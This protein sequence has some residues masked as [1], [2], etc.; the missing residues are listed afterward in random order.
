MAEQRRSLSFS[1]WW[2]IAGGALAM[3]M[4]GTFQ[5]VWSSI[6]GPL[7]TQIGTTEATLGTLFT[8]VI[9]VQTVVQFPA[10]WVRDRYGPR[11]PTLAG[12]LLMTGGYVGLSIASSPV[13]AGLAVVAG[14]GGAGAIYTVAV[15]TPV[16][17][18]DEYRGLATGIITMSYAVLSFGLIPLTRGSILG[19]FQRTLL[20]FAVLAALTCLLAAIILRDPQI[21]TTPGGT[22]EKTDPV[23]ETKE[24]AWTDVIQTW[25]FWILYGAFVIVNGVGLMLIGKLIAFSD[26]MELSAGVAT[27]AASIIAIADGSGVLIVGGLSDR[28][29]SI[30]TVGSS[31]LLSAIGIAGAVVSGSSGIAPV[32]IICVAVAG[33]FRSPVFAI[34]PTL[35]GEYYGRKYSSE[36]YATLY[37]AKLWG[38]LFAGSVASILITRVG[39]S[40]SFLI[41]AI[42]M[43]LAGLS[44]FTIRP[45]S[46]LKRS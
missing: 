9:A 19:T 17:W 38:S 15:N 46:N 32:F 13:T 7:G 35:I 39:W 4:A 3:G 41:G 24:Y 22:A 10:G 27:A 14:G 36:N 31:L 43:G 20:F 2:L 18:F 28:L 5:F 1:R 34:F 11:I 23:T 8:L 16:K 45:V 25:Q 37:T 42:L 33:F 29:G 6:R 12:A 40:I 26:A 44:V 30:R 21:D